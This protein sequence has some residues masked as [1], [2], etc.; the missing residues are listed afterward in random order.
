M[1]HLAYVTTVIRALRCSDMTTPSF[2]LELPSVPC[3][4]WWQIGLGIASLLIIV[5]LPVYV[6]GLYV[7]LNA[8]NAAKVEPVGLPDDLDPEAAEKRR[9]DEE[10]SRDQRNVAF[11]GPFHDDYWWWE[12]VLAL[13]RIVSALVFY[14]SDEPLTRQ[15]ILVF[16]A[17]LYVVAAAAVRPFAHPRAH[18]LDVLSSGAVV[19][20]SIIA[21]AD[22]LLAI[23]PSPTDPTAATFASFASSLQTAIALLP[24]T[25]AS[26]MGALHMR[27]V[28]AEAMRERRAKSAMM[29][30]AN[31][32]AVSAGPA[33]GGTSVDGVSGASAATEKA[34]EEVGNVG[35]W[36]RGELRED[37]PPHS[38]ARIFGAEGAA[39]DSSDDFGDVI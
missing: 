7:W 6:V 9:R 21:L 17:V 28:A 18:T 32:K 4:Q 39:R 10:A 20:T 37:E 27:N 35:G 2:L 30:R 12:C 13:E 29:R 8:R 15:S 23:T 38:G 5:P 22:A 19:G 31:A 24:I 16:V 36:L 11:S 26:A 34:V 1:S 14:F 25:G 3:F 33:R